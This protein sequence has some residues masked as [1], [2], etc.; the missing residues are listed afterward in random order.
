MVT[1]EDKILGEKVHNYCSS[2]EDEADNDHSSTDNKTSGNAKSSLQFVPENKLKDQ[3]FFSAC[4]ANTG[5]KGV[6]N[7]WQRFKQLEAE[8]REHQEKEKLELIKKL[9]IITCSDSKNENTDSQQQLIDDLAD[10]DDDNFLLEYQKKRMSEMLALAGKQPA[11]GV[12]LEIE[13]GVEFLKAVDNEQKSVTVIIHIY[14]SNNNA[15]KN[16]NDALVDLATEYTNVKFCK[17]KSSIAG[18]SMT[19]KVSG[20]PALLVYKAGQIIG[21]FVRLTDDLTDDF[22]TSDV[23][24]FLIEVGM[25]PDKYSVPVIAIQNV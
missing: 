1:L 15:C 16:M 8:K 4:T 5:P 21:N 25:L 6:I 19:F 3:T 9:S 11:F 14:D 13:N 10:T 2:S 17:F 20:L 12:L 18:L 24:S 7:D 22:N 23:E